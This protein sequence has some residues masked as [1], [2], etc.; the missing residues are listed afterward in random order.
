MTDL[1]M[2]SLCDIDTAPERNVGSGKK[3]LA[4]THAL[5]IC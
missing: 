4:H 2:R 1:A 5:H 3:S